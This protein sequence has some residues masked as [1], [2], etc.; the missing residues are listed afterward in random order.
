MKTTMKKALLVAAMT[1]MSV[2]VNTLQAA[3]NVTELRNE[4]EIMTNILQTSLK[5]NSPQKGIRSHSVEVTYLVDQGVLFEIRTAG[6]EGSFDFNFNRVF[7]GFVVPSAPVA[8][9][10]QLSGGRVELNMD[11]REL[12]IFVEDAMEH[13]QEQMHNSRDQLRE[14]AE[15]QREI[16]WEQ[17]DYERRRRDL[18]FEK[19][20]ADSNS[21]KNID[22]QLAELAAETAKLEAKRVEVE[23]YNKKL[24]TEQ[25]QLAE[26]RL[27]TK[28]K[29]YSEFLA[30]FESSISN[31]LCSY[32]AGIKALPDNENISFILSDFGSAAA[33][34]HKGKQD[35][36][37]V[38]KNEDVQACVRD[39]MTPQKLLNGA[40]TYLF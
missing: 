1:C 9:V 29:Q 27:A 3:T 11:E 37:Y 26:Q 40:N 19:H 36:V 10:V 4:L 2:N 17:R 31:V 28:I 15:Q 14:L 13:A 32:G 18:E 34:G 6:T 5:Q 38:F 25:K 30:S 22:E 24:E 7:D 20:N 33:T 39:K 21:R 35:K 16:A 12:E 23:R 8:P